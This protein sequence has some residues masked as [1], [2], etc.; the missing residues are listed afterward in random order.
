[1][2]EAG[3]SVV[4]I[5]IDLNQGLA[6]FVAQLNGRENFPGTKGYITSKLAAIHAVQ[7]STDDWFQT[8]VAILVLLNTQ[9]S[10]I[11]INFKSGIAV[12]L[13]S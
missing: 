7:M 5:K 11:Q 3:N 4:F 6:V 8:Y 13:F 12:S 1:M 10:V 9:I 2:S